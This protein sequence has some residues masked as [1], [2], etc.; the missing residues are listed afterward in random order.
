M[1]GPITHSLSY[2]QQYKQY[3]G[4][5]FFISIDQG[6]NCFEIDG[7]VGVVRNILEERVDGPCVGYVVFEEF[8]TAHSFFT[9]PLDSVDM[10]IFAV[11]KLSGV[12]TIC[13][14]TDVK[15]KCFMLPYK[16]GFVVMPQMHFY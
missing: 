1:N 14:L 3:H 9:E 8:A 13:K 2:C 11:G 15:M 16:E 7:K 6:D 5:R 4:P 10:S 12:R